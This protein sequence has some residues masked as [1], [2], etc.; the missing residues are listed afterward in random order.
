MFSCEICEISKNTFFIEHLWWLLLNT[1]TDSLD[2]TNTLLHSAVRNIPV[3]AKLKC[4]LGYCGHVY[5]GAV[6]PS[7][8]AS[9]NIRNNLLSLSANIDNVKEPES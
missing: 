1:Q 5:F 6:R 8:T 4:K 9:E 2:I 7:Y 3:I